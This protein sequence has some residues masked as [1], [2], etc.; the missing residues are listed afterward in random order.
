M[1][2]AK[3]RQ[4]TFDLAASHWMPKPDRS[5][6]ALRPEEPKDPVQT[7]DMVGMPMG[8]ED[9]RE[10]LGR[11]IDPDQ[12]TQNPVASVEQEVH[13]WG[14]DEDLGGQPGLA[15]EQRNPNALAIPLHARSIPGGWVSS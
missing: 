4:D 8:E 2:V 11:D 14:P 6:M 9:P 13:L 1:T 10:D 7:S 15:V 5:F 12:V 3:R